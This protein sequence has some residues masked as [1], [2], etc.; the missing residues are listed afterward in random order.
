M[1][2]TG[3]LELDLFTCPR[4]G[5]RLTTSACARRSVRGDAL[6]LVLSGSSAG[7]VWAPGRWSH[8]AGCRDC[9]VGQSHA[10]ELGIAAPEGGPK[11]SPRLTS[12]AKADRRWIDHE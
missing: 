9:P 1:S 8:C 4:H 11:K 3:G 6:Y 7:H 5:F 10:L 2:N 12:P